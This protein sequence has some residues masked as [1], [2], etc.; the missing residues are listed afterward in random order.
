[1]KKILL[2]VLT[3]V[4]FSSSAIGQSRTVTGTVVSGEDSPVSKIRL[5]VDGLPYGDVTKKNGTFKIEK[6]Q[7]EDSIIV[8][9]KNKNNAKFLLGDCST[10]KLTLSNDMVTV[11]RDGVAMESVTAQKRSFGSNNSN[12]NIITAKM[13][14]RLHPRTVADAI[15]MRS[16]GFN[17]APISVNSAK[18]PLVF[19]DGIETTFENVNSL[20]IETI[21]TIEINKHGE[22][23]GARGAAGV[24]TVTQKKQ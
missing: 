15:R 17:S 16:P 3:I 7:S 13:I 6:V 24:I 8:Q 11:H 4:T 20:P 9:L 19:L 23:Y 18:I 2:F 5:T 14:D 22:G 12:S 10:L 1:M 21:E